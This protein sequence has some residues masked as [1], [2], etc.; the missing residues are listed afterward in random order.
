MAAVAG[1]TD[2]WHDE[3]RGRGGRGQ[4]TRQRVGGMRGARELASLASTKCRS[5]RTPPLE[6]A[7]RRD[8]WHCCEQT[9]Y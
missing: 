7:D 2:V 8:E 6:V 5:S 1:V 3:W 4:K 9:T